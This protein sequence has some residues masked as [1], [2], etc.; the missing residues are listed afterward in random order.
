MSSYKG[1]RWFKC[2]LH[3]QTPLEPHWREES[4]AVAETHDVSLRHVQVVANPVTSGPRAKD[5]IQ[6]SIS[7][8]RDLGDRIWRQHRDNLKKNEE[9]DGGTLSVKSANRY[10]P[11]RNGMPGYSFRV[12]RVESGE[13]N[14]SQ[15]LFESDRQQ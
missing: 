4:T 11:M 8:C 10:N 7:G 12:P 2:D 3:V 13:V 15:I 1:M 6:Q 9:T 14:F 5:G